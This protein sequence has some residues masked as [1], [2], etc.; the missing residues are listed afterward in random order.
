MKGCQMRF[1]L[2]WAPFSGSET[3]YAHSS[4]CWHSRT[5]QRMRLR[6]PQRARRP[7]RH[8]RHPSTPLRTLRGR[9]PS[10]WPGAQVPKFGTLGGGVGHPQVALRALALLLLKKAR[11]TQVCFRGCPRKRKSTPQLHPRHPIRPPP[12]RLIHRSA[13]QRKKGIRRGI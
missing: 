9:A 8:R 12:P 7:K 3:F 13:I 10:R 5:S 1:Q 11:A 6:A 2:T 4:S